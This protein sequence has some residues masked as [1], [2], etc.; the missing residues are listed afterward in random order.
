MSI[1]ERVERDRQLEA[2][3]LGA[4]G[5]AVASDAYST[6]ADS[7]ES[8]SYAPSAMTYNSMDPMEKSELAAAAMVSTGW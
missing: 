2:A 4:S 6:V 3:E 8:S 1:R 5:A 7:A